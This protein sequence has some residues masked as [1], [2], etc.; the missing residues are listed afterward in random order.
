MN[1]DDQGRANQNLTRA[2]GSCGPRRASDSKI[3]VTELER[4]LF[5]NDEVAP[6]C[7]LVSGETDP[8][9]YDKNGCHEASVKKTLGKEDELKKNAQRVRQQ[10]LREGHRL[11]SDSPP[12]LPH[13]LDTGLEDQRK[14]ALLGQRVV[15]FMKAQACDKS[16]YTCHSYNLRLCIESQWKSSPWESK[17]AR[18]LCHRSCKEAFDF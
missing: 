8:T 17:S 16:Q 4:Y 12:R 10:K 1:P 11:S 15:R 6:R 14:C 5:P 7:L 18:V 3:A 13:S 9:R 2:R